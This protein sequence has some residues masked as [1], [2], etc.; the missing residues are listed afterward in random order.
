MSISASEVSFRKRLA[1]EWPGL[2]DTQAIAL[3]RHYELML[4][5]NVRLNLTRV[6]K[7]EDAVRFHYGESLFLARV[8]P[9]GALHIVDV[10][11]GAGFPGIPIAVVRPECTVDLVDSDRRKAVFLREATRD[12]ANTTVIAKRAEDFESNYDWIVSRAVAVREVLETGLAPK[13][14]L[15]IGESDASSAFEV[16]N[17]PW[18][19]RRVVGLFHVEQRSAT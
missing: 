10:G 14:A 18:V 11:S 2:T 5:W 13:A 19:E 6:T 4:R 7:L 9:P 16:R 1:E 12:I 8:L 15:L 17:L 3:A